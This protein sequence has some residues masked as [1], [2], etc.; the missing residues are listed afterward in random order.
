LVLTNPI[1]ASF[2]NGVTEISATHTII[3]D[4]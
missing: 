4:D 1:G 2:N 3:D